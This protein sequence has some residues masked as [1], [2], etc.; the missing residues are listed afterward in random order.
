MMPRPRSRLATRTT[1]GVVAALGLFLLI[2]SCGTP[3]KAPPPAGRVVVFA[4]SSLAEAFDDCAGKMSEK[5]VQLRMSYGGSQ[6][7]AAQIANGAI[8]DVYASADERWMREMIQGGH[9]VDEPKVF[10]HNRLAV[11]IPISTQSTVEKLQDMARPGVRVVLGVEQSPIGRYS[12]QA[13]AK[14]S[15]LPGFGTDFAD[16]VLANVVSSED[17]VKQVVAKVQLREADAGIVYQSD[18]TDAVSRYAAVI[19]IPDTANVVATYEIAVL[20][21]SANP[22][23]ARAFIAFLLSSEGQAVL[24]ERGFLPAV[25]P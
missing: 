23:A 11:I 6:L 9:V 19:T 16:R 25:T 1:C 5:E 2:P 15:T 21:K 20:R 24:A 10:A 4:A 13:L 12:R 17:D 22:R 3:S 8:G 18:L 7:L 14:L